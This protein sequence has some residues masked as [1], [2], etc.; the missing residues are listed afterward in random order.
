MARFGGFFHSGRALSR[1]CGSVAHP[2]KR[3]AHDGKRSGS[4]AHIIEQF[5]Q[6]HVRRWRGASP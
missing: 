1:V 6:R 3:M 5:G 2:G 4:L